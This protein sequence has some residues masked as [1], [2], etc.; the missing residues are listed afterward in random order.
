MFTST[1]P[2]S[3]RYQVAADTGWPSRR[4]VV[5]TAGFGLRSMA[6][7]ASGSGGF[8]MRASKVSY[9]DAFSCHAAHLAPPYICSVCCPGAIG[10]SALELLQTT[11]ISSPSSST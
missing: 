9:R 4:R 1:R 11:P 3:H 10:T 8:D 7:A 6:T 2:S 5:M